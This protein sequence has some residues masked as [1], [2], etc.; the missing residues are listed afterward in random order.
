MDTSSEPRKR[1]RPSTSQMLKRY[2]RID[3]SWTQIISAAESLG[4][5]TS[6][7]A[8][9]VLLKDATRVHRTASNGDREN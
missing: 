9:R 4:Q 1:G 6:E 3:E 2:F 5:S 7:Y 8:R